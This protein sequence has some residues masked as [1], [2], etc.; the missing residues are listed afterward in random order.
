VLRDRITEFYIEIDDFC[1]EFASK[2]KT[3]TLLD[4]SDIKRRN[5]KGK[6]SDAEMMSIYLLFHFGQFTNFKS[7]YKRYVCKHLTD[8]FPDLISYERFNERQ[9]RILLPLMLYLKHRGG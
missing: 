7:F 8:L 4:D 6:L 1:L 9:D 2:L 5:R 3:Q